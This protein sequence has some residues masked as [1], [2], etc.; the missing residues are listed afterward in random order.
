LQPPPRPAFACGSGPLVASGR[1]VNKARRPR[2]PALRRGR[3]FAAS[4]CL[5]A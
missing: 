5:V 4:V 2:A 3:D 1:A